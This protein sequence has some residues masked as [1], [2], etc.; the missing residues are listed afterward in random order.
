MTF[1]AQSYSGIWFVY[2][3]DCPICSYA[4][5]ALR[6]RQEFGSMHLL[7]AR[8]N[9]GDPLIEEINRRWLDLD[10][11]MVI[12]QEGRFIHGGQGLRFMALYGEQAGLFNRLNRL[13]FKSERLAAWSYPFLRAGRNLLLRLRGR[14]QIDNLVSPGAPTFQA[15]FGADWEALPPVLKAHYAN[16]PFSE[17]VTVVQGALD[18]FCR[19][20]LSWLAPIIR[21]VGTIPPVSEN[22][23]PITV[24]FESDPETRAFHFNRRFEFSS[25][26]P[27]VFHSRMIPIRGNELIEV[28]KFG[29]GWRTG[30][31]WREDKV[32]LEHKGYGL[33]VGSFILPLPLTFLIGRGIAEERAID[34]THFAMSVV[35]RHWLFGDV[36]GY[37]GTFE[38]VDA[39][40]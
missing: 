2:D 36:Y 24:R 30:F 8:E 13:L 32:V 3:G 15:V 21:L 17:D 27:Y 25:T 11:G 7:D 4:A 38:L 26:R 23:V 6:I 39:D 18:V 14:Q 1:D 19:A 12:Y 33:K 34:E 22:G 37:A 20:P 29:I 5:H 31:V 28:M 9:E 16:R 35:I 10:E 40:G